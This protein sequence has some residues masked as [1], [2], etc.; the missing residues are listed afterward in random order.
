TGNVS[1][2]QYVG[3][4]VGYNDNTVNNSYFNG[5]VNGTDSVGG[6]VGGNGIDGTVKNSYATGDVSG[7]EHLVGGLVGENYGEVNNSYATGAVNGTDYVGGLV[8]LNYGVV[9]R[10]YSTG[11]VT[12]NAFSGGLVGDNDGT[13]GNSFWDN[14]TSGQQTSS[15]G[16]GL[17]TT[18][19]MTESTFSGWNFTDTWWMVDG[20]TRPFLQMEW[21]TKVSNSHQLQMM[22]MDT[23]A[24]YKLTDDIDLSGIQ[25]ASQM[26]GTDSTSGNG[27]KMIGGWSDHFTGSFDGDGY[28]ISDLHINRTWSVGLF[29]KVGNDTYSGNVA[30]VTLKNVNITGTTPV[31]ALTGTLENGT[32]ENCHVTGRITGIY[33]EE[34]DSYSEQVGGLIGENH[35]TVKNCSSTADVTVSYFGSEVGGLI[36]EN[37]GQMGGT[38]YNGIVKNSYSTGNV[39]GEYDVGGLIGENFQG[40]LENTYSTGNVIGE[41]YIGG[42]IGQNGD[43]GFSGIVY[44]SYAAGNVSGSSE[45]GGLIG[46][47]YQGTVT[48]SYWDIETTGQNTSAG[49]A[50][51]LT[52][53]E[54]M[55]KSTFSGW[56]FDNTWW[57]IEDV[58]YPLL[59]WQPGPE[60]TTSSLELVNDPESGGWNFISFNLNPVD[61]DLVSILEDEQ[62]GISGNY[63]KVMYYDASTDE[64]LSYIPGRDNFNDDIQWDETKGL[65]IRMTAD[66]SLTVEGIEP[67]STD[68][69]LNPGWNMVGYPSS[70]AAV[71]GTPTEVSIVGYFD[72]TQENNLAYDYDPDNF[73]FAPG[74][75]Y[76]LYNDADYDVTWTVEY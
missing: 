66:D 75:G 24:D 12:G 9:N 8:G 53:D 29:Y 36:G 48:D 25:D 34:F 65:W 43:S 13:V 5:N 52:T 56:D 57:M 35:D 16:T 33:N 47:N 14:E 51:G 40:N 17:N 1:G 20:E 4:L 22:D 41:D 58:T 26:W 62:Y 64:W 45:V 19:I 18:E 60:T 2:Y 15:G 55:T 50:T 31:G 21:D 76:Y 72:A 67:T 6:L 68:I 39:S 71:E 32:V 7:E 30:N 3:G 10:S 38:Y 63:D 70:T 73:E 69:T 49:N 28:T 23:S 61:K 44:Y 11:Y 59:T 42:L 74:E 46:Y 54:M 27:F 37:G